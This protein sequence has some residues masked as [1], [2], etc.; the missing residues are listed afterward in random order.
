VS[1][2]LTHSRLSCFR[3]C[4][5]RHLLRY[6]YLLTP[7]RES[8]A[9]RFGSAFHLAAEAHATGA[10]VEA[11]VGASL[12]DP[13]DLAL[14]AATFAG[15]VERWGSE[16]LE[17]V[18]AEAAFDLPL[19][20]PDTGASTPLFRLGGRIDRVVRLADGRLA[21]MEMKTTSRDFSPGADY[22]MRLHL[23]QQVSIYVLAARELGYDVQTIL[24]DVT[25]RPALRPYQVNTR[26]AVP[27]TPEEYAA[28]V[29]EDI[30]VRPDYYF[31][32]IEIARLDA[33]LVECQREV[34]QQQLALRSAQ[35]S[36]FW[37][38]NPES[39]YSASGHSCDFLAICQ[40]RDLEH[41]TPHGFHRRETPH[42]ELASAT[43]GG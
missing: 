27:E 9:L 35:K 30:R 29:G 24:Y 37:Y 39:C 5:R 40:Q 1:N 42:P 10:D 2:V 25:R 20:N 6:E 7:D 22:W 21:L 13:Y 31:A 28:R 23:D 26:R 34:W 17:T 36:G 11:A 16:P 33:D 41:E 38:R 15:Y 4:P 32:R 3:A 43:S 12:E 19:R 14:L 8:L 18:V